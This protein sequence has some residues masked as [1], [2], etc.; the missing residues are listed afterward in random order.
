MA[1]YELDYEPNFP[2]KK[3]LSSLETILER[4]QRLENR[5]TRLEQR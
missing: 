1:S 5:V 3:V 4:L 2:Y